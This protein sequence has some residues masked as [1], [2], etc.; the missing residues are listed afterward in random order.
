MDPKTRL[1][2]MANGYQNS[3]ILLSAC[4][5]GIFAAIGRGSSTAAATA[6]VCGL[7]ER[8]TE[9]I[10]LALAA[11]G[12]LEIEGDRFRIGA[13]E[14]E[15]LLPDGEGTQA[16][17]FNHLHGLLQRW[18]RLDEVL[19]TGRPLQ[20]DPTDPETLRDFIL[21]MENVSRTSSVEVEGKVDLRGRK[22]LL[23][24]GGGP[25]TAAITFASAHPQL[26]CVVFD[27][28]G[29]ILIAR[30]QVAA[31]G[32][33]GRIELRAGDY[34]ADDVGE[35]FDV[36]YISNI[37]HAHDESEVALL[38]RKA[39]DAL[40][41]GGMAVVKDFFLEPDRVRPA[42]AARFSVNMLVA[43]PGGRSYTWDETEKMMRE[44]GFR[45]LRRESVARVSGLILG[46]R[47]SS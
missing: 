13:A 4:R 33:D 2:E 22:R 18:A 25:A 37:I 10:L 12:V 39:H 30:D 45:G 34:L 28:P 31:A 9:R 20:S 41:P 15:I 44:A 36:V 32:M 21:G 40:E 26:E 46:E 47:A 38:L 14:A 16:S 6:A 23:D 3:A 11:A 7:D 1:E 5:C 42:R 24:L 27:L 35:G 8:A 19:R 17:I 43:T 29:P